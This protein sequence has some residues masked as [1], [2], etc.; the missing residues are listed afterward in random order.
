MR[1]AGERLVQ[2]YVFVKPVD[3]LGFFWYDTLLCTSHGCARSNVHFDFARVLLTPGF[4]LPKNDRS[5]C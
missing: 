2:T 5:I 1:G 4:F 3:R